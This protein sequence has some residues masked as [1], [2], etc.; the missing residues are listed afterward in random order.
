MVSR[1]SFSHDDQPAS[2]RNTFREHFV[3]G[4][5]IECCFACTTKVQYELKE[6]L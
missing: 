3:F 4:N 2:G 6:D 5:V 1:L